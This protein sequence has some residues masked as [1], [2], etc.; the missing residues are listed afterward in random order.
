MSCPNN[1]EKVAGCYAKSVQPKNLENWNSKNM[2]KYAWK[3]TEDHCDSESLNTFGPC[4]ITPEQ[5]AALNNGKGEA[6]R[7]YDDDGELMYSGVIADFANRRGSVSYSGFEPLED[8]GMPNV[9]CTEIHYL[10]KTNS[11]MKWK[12]L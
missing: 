6:F 11:G 9:G 12:Q 8:F 2:N 10:E 3:I 4:D 1:P 7:M 5:E